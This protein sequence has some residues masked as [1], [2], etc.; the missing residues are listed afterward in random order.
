MLLDALVER[1]H[2]PSGDPGWHEGFDLA[3]WSPKGTFG[4]HVTVV[5]WPALARAWYWTAVVE[6]DHPVVALVETDAALPAS[7]LELRASGLWADHN[8]ET[9]GAHW[10]YGLEAFAVRLDHPDDALGAFRGERVGLGHDLEWEADDRAAV[11]WG[12]A[13]TRSEEPASAGGY[14]RDGRVHG[15]VLIGPDAY[16]LDGWGRRSHWWGVTWWPPPLRPP[17]APVGGPVGRSLARLPTPTG[18][19]IVERRLV[20]V[21]GRPSW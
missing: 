15:E 5:L 9:P 14:H 13:A 4:G 7:G 17:A 3:Y 20:V 18:A 21:D 12:T 1:R 19:E 16:E 6:R 11:D 2:R 10:S 8:C